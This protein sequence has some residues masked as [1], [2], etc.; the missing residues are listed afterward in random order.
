MPHPPS[1]PPSKPQGSPV[2]LFIQS[3]TMGPASTVMPMSGFSFVSPMLGACHFSPNAPGD[4]A[5]HLH[6]VSFPFCTPCRLL[7]GPY[8][9][10]PPMPS[11]PPLHFQREAH[12]WFLLFMCHPKLC[13]TQPH[14][15]HCVFHFLRAWSTRAGGQ[16]G[17]MWSLPLKTPG[18]HR[19][20]RHTLAAPLFSSLSIGIGVSGQRDIR[21]KTLC[22]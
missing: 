13:S 18:P 5:A 1:R 20:M 16:G 22:I 2:L 19:L 9:S 7:P 12:M 14:S 3:A 21:E 17:K 11:E 8:H 6:P 15:Q 10:G 4:H